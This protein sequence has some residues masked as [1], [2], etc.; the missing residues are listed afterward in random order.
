MKI[1]NYSEKIDVPEGIEME[2]AGSTVTLKGKAGTA[3]KTFNMPAFK[4][5]KEGNSLVVSCPGYGIYEKEKINAVAAHIKNMAHGCKEG[6]TYLLKICASHFPMTV[7]VS[8]NKL[9]VK[10]LIGEKIPREMI[11]KEGAA[12]KVAESVIEVKGTNLEIVSQVAAD[13][14]KLTKIRNRDRR[15]FQD[16][17]YIT[18]KNE[19]AI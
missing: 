4:F 19:E 15:I 5:K 13:I 7:T 1:K 14:E 6:Y 18:H 9:I 8:G 3:S 16:G 17:I 12:I 11:I 10:N 2:L